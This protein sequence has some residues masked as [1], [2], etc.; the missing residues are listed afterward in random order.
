MEISRGAKILAGALGLGV[1]IIGAT[2]MIGN[3]NKV[4]T[5][6]VS[7]VSEGTTLF[8]ELTSKVDSLKTGSLD[9]PRFN[10]LEVSVD[11]YFEQKLITDQAANSLKTSIN[12]I[13]ALRVYAYCEAFLKGRNGNAPECI[14]LLN[15]LQGK[16]GANNQILMYRTQIKWFQYYSTTLPNKVNTFVKSGIGNYTDEEYQRLK[17]EVQ[18]MPGLSPIY[19]NSNRFK[20]INS[21]LIKDLYQFNYDY[22]K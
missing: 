11:S 10:T 20:T 6:L 5:E 4:K 7:T 18:N 3:T 12:R 17:D 1:L 13:F 19:K 15:N 14:Q 21:K 2:Q 8:N 9:V 16:I 22:S